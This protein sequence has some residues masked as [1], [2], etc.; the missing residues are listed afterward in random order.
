M[1]ELIALFLGYFLILGGVFLAHEVLSLE[2]EL[3]Y[4]ERLEVPINQ[5]EL[6]GTRS[7]LELLRVGIVGEYSIF[8]VGF[9]L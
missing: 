5:I 1:S 8:L 4:S 2:V 7:D 9:V 3:Q 6:L